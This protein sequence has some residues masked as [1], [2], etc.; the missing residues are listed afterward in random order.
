MRAVSAAGSRP[1]SSGRQHAA[2]TLSF[3]QITLKPVDR[4]PYFL[5][6]LESPDEQIAADAMFELSLVDWSVIFQLKMQMDR[7]KLR[8]KLLDPDGDEMLKTYY[9]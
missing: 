4:L 2:T 1:A 6:H 3:W 7:K 5:K 9:P 8:H